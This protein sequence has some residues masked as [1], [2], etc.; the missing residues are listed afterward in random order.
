MKIRLTNSG[1]T[2]LVLSLALIVFRII[3]P[4]VSILSWDVF[5]YYLYLPARFIYHNLSL[6]DQ[7]WL[8]ELFNI[9]QPSSSLYQAQLLESGNWVIKYPGGVAILL[10]PFF[11]IGHAIALLS[12]YPADGLS[13]PYQYSLAAGGIVYAIIGLIYL[14][15]ILKHFFSEKIT[16]LLLII[17]TAGT[18]Y[19]QLTAFD[20]TLLSHNFLFTLY[21]ML[22]WF[23]IRWHQKPT[24]LSSILIGVLCGMIILTRPSEIVCL[25]IPLLWNIKNNTTL[26]EKFSLFRRHIVKIIIACLALIIVCSPQLVYWKVITGHFLFYSYTDP[27]VGFSFKSPFISEFLFSF[28][29]G[30]FIYTPVMIFAII[31][32][33]SLF[34]KKKELFATV[35]LFILADVYIVSSWSCW[36]YAGGSFSSRS[37]VPAYTLLALPLGFLIEDVIRR[38]SGRIVFYTIA[39][40]LVALNLFQ[41][42]QFE[43][44]I[45]TK[46]TMT[47]KYYFSVFGKT[48]ASVDDR[49]LL[50]IEHGIDI[51]EYFNNENEYLKRNLFSFDFEDQKDTGLVCHSGSGAF[52]MDSVTQ[53]SPGIDIKYCDIT[54][55]NHA[56]IRAGVW[57]FIPE[58]YSGEMPLLTLTF[59]H[60]NDPYKYRTVELPASEIKKGGWNF[61]SADYLTPEV[62]S[63]EDNM[64]VYIWHRS[65]DVVYIDDFKVDVYEPKNN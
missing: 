56:W 39:S 3:L 9:Y 18:N 14:R 1:K 49:K 25:I 57:I 4:P 30:W 38:K 32:L 21:A 12:G 15:K 47:R 13:L 62:R 7:S 31:G 6:S 59:H 16:I 28:R 20:G 22:I 64:K 41:T 17:I 43:N 51:V 34:R 61:L 63:T 65:K 44:G 5:G 54:D 33:I 37:M 60:N 11:F 19:F 46:E 58:N 35:L 55:K 10:A 52:R 53:Y 29:K 42:W 50:S 23:T 45:I 26:I 40:L 2:V 24:V 36:W 8:N 27:S 48:Y